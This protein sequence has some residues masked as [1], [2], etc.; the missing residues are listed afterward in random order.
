MHCC[1]WQL[2]ILVKYNIRCSPRYDSGP[3]CILIYSNDISYNISSTLRMSADDTQLYKELS[4]TARD[5]EALQSDIDQLV[6]W[7]SK[8]QLHFNPDKCEALFITHKRALSVP[9]KTCEVHKG[10][11]DLVMVSSDLSWS[12]HVKAT[13]N[14][15]NKLLFFTFCKSL[16]CLIL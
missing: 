12:E 11:V 13:I 3:S 4:N 10:F 7:A 16:V 9:S 8:W 5:S 1:S 2:L 14:K 15:A 6:S